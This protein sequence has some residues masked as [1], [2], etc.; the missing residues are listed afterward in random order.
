[1]N[2]F[3]VGRWHYVMPKFK[4]NGEGKMYLIL[5]LSFGPLETYEYGMTQ[6]GKFYKDYHWCE[7]DFFEDSDFYKEITKEEMLQ[8]IIETK[9][10]C[11]EHQWDE[12]VKIYE[13][14]QEYLVND[15]GLEFL[16]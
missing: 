10:L 3:F 12:G 9:E 7:D 8:E 16:I 4:F 13:K 15:R 5:Q 14:I 6:Q 2:E 1:M 11:K